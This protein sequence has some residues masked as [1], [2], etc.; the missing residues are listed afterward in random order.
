MELRRIQAWAEAT[1]VGCMSSTSGC[2]AMEEVSH[3][4]SLWNKLSKG[5]GSGRMK[6]AK[7]QR[8]R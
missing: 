4:R 3:A 8:R 2:G 5:E 6:E 7:E 1:E